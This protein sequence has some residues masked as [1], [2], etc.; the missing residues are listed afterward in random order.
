MKEKEMSPF[1]IHAVEK[2]SALV[3]KW[4]VSAVKDGRWNVGDRLPPERAIA[5]QLGVSRTAVRE[6]LSSLHMVDLIEPRVGDGN[7][8]IRSIEAETDIEDALK[9][10]AESKSLVEIWIIRKKLEIIIARLA[11]RKATVSDIRE[12]DQYL[13]AIEEAVDN[14]DADAYL[15]ANSDFHRVLARAAKNPFLRRSVLPL[16]E[17]TEYQ[18]AREVSKSTVRDHGVHLVKM[19]RDILDAII[20]HDE[21]HIVEIMANHF[22]S[23]EAVF[24]KRPKPRNGGDLLKET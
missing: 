7:Y 1:V 6:A 8:L 19:H 5:E 9:A 21:E 11:L 10:I 13:K 23:S 4:V 12:L 16:I 14:M 15:S 3:V 18:L 2:K 20:N 24:L 17:I 22:R